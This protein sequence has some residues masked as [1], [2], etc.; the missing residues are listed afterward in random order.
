M[1]KCPTCG[2]TFIR[3]IISAG[4]TQTVLWDGDFIV[5][6][7]TQY[8]KTDKNSQYVCNS[9]LKDLTDV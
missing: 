9:C 6:E 1:M 4:I 8:D 3:E 7:I 5:Q 2:G